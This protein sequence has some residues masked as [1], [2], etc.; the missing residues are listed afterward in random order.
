M[1]LLPGYHWVPVA[2]ALLYGMSTPLGIA[3]GLGVRATYNPVGMV[4]SIV[5]GVLDSVSSGILLYTGLVEVRLLLF[6]SLHSECFFDVA[7]VVVGP[8]VHVQP[9][10]PPH[11]EW[12]V[13]V[14]VGEHDHWGGAYGAI[15]TLGMR[16]GPCLSIFRK[17]TSPTPRHARTIIPT[18]QLRIEGRKKRSPVREEV[19]MNQSSSTLDTIYAKGRI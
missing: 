15:G 1:D 11:V 14:C 16:I 4:A 13:G 8:R 17:P 9:Q 18:V 12:E 2:G 3:I 7:L 5:S 19:I 10:D 6:R